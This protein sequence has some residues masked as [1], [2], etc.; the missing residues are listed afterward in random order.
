MT[1]I[2]DNPNQGAKV[3]FEILKAGAQTK[4]EIESRQ[5]DL[6]RLYQEQEAGLR[7]KLAE[8]LRKALELA[9]EFSPDSYSVSIGVPI[10]GTIGFT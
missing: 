5:L 4:A 10:V 9:K 2:L 1:G 8:W 6:T 3:L 7:D